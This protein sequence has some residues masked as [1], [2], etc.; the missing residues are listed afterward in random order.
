MKRLVLLN[1][2]L[3]T[4]SINASAPQEQTIISMLEALHI[5]SPIENSHIPYQM[6]HQ[7]PPT[8]KRCCRRLDF[9]TR[10]TDGKHPKKIE[11]AKIFIIKKPLVNNYIAKK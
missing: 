11:S 4:I 8:P 7:M 9:G 3:G 6:P 1:A 2:L 10:D 5:N